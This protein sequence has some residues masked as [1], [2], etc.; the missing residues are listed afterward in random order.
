MTKEGVKLLKQSHHVS[1]LVASRSLLDDVERLL[2]LQINGGP[3]V[4]GQILPLLPILIH[5]V[6]GVQ[7]CPNL[8]F[9]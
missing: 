8:V 5:H 6:S 2:R 3:I 7:H 9:V 4:P 1:M